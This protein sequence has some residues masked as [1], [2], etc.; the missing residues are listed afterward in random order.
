M[1]L[2]C[3][4]LLGQVCQVRFALSGLLCQ[5]CQVWFARPGLLGQVFLDKVCRV[6]FSE[7]C[8]LGWGLQDL[9]LVGGGDLLGWLGRFGTLDNLPN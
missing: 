6:R 1:E 5:V 7:S 3:W 8:L 4:G 2:A 9:V